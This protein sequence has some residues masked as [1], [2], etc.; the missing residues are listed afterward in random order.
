MGYQDAAEEEQ[1]VARETGGVGNGAVGR[2]A[3]RV[4]RATRDHPDVRVG[5]S[6][7]GAIDLSLLA[8]Q[9]AVLRDGEATAEEIGLDAALAALSGRIRVREG[10]GRDPE[11][12]VRELWAAHRAEPDP[13]RTDDGAADG[14]TDPDAAAG[15]GHAGSSKSL[16]PRA[17][18]SRSR[19]A[20]DDQ[21][22]T[23]EGDAVEE[24]IAEAGRRTSSRQALAR[25]PGFE[26]VSPAVGQLDETAFDD[27]LSD[28]PDQALALLAELTGATD[29]RLREQARRL[30][31][32]VVVDVVRSGAPRRSG[33]GRLRHQRADRSSG[34]IDLDRGLEAVAAAR[35][36]G[37]APA[38]GDLHARE[39]ARPGLAL[40]LL[41][42]RSGS[43]GGQRL[44]SASV[45]AAACLWRAPL[46]TSVVAFA[47][48]ALVLAPQGSGRDPE[49]VVDDL[50]RLRGHGPT[51]IAL[52]LRTARAQLDR[53]TASRRITILLSDARPTKGG[54]PTL[55]AATLDELVVVA[56]EGD[57]TEAAALAAS[58]GGRWTEI[59]GPASVPDALTE[60]LGA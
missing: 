36:Q 49:R 51:D 24:A 23:A 11:D 8:D 9:L 14:G 18:G 3:V 55:E 25:N 12:V 19:D 42:D 28:D 5:S 52:A 29:E 44:A 26:Q 41:I 2:R 20:L 16:S 22:R 17:G 6:V 40:C 56:P 57:S 38:L 39:W 46:D 30:A 32:R 54:D 59:A 33:V 50:L 53:S 4:V 21:E 48:D 1:I 43:M 27:A 37:A 34:E 31:G 13:A 47:D 7:R 45:A 15:G 10:S 35:A 58:V 60:V